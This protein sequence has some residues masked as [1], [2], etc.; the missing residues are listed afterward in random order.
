MKTSASEK[1]KLVTSLG[2][3][4]CSS[5]ATVETTD[6]GGRAENVSGK[7]TALAFT[8]CA[9][10]V[11]GKPLECAVGGGTGNA[12]DLPYAATIAWTS[13][14]NGTLTASSG[15]SGNPGATMV[16]EATPRTSKP[17]ARSSTAPSGQMP[18]QREMDRQIRT[19]PAERRQGLR[20]E[21]TPADVPLQVAGRGYLSRLVAA[22]RRNQ[23][24]RDQ[25]DD[26]AQRRFRAR[27]RLGQ[28]ENDDR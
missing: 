28:V 14:A 13:G 5:T 20:P 6:E 4:T 7:V 22:G 12:N 16:S 21:E 23:R 24:H 25:L 19:H 1:A 3:I 11:E 2:T 27:L 17:A 8:E 9:L 10:T 26:L 15:G 18:F